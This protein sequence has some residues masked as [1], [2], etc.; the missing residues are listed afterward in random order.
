MNA[1]RAAGWTFHVCF[2]FG[3]PKPG[4]LDGFGR[5]VKLPLL[6]LLEDLLEGVCCPGPV[7]GINKALLFFRGTRG[8]YRG[9]K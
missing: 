6:P 3:T 5:P 8:P 7:D 2:R 9:Q 4:E 1:F